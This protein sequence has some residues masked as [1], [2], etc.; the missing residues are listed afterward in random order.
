MPDQEC[1]CI[2]ERLTRHPG[3]K[4]G[5][6]I[7]RLT[8]KGDAEWARFMNHVNRCMHQRLEK[9]GDSDLFSQIDWSVQEDSKLQDAEPDEIRT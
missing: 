3:S 8:Y 6:V 7:Y 4:L 9:S 2:R 5:F 1:V